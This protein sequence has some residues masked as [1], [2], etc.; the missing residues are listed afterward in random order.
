MEERQAEVVL[1]SSFGTN[2]LLS[3]ALEIAEQN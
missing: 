3:V 2:G 1:S